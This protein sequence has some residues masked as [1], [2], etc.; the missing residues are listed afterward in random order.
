MWRQRFLF[1]MPSPIVTSSNLLELHIWMTHFTDL[2]YLLD[3]RFN[4]LHTFH[5]NILIIKCTSSTIHSGEKLPNLR[6]FSLCSVMRIHF[7]DELI[8]PL[9]H[10][11]LNLEKLDL[12][13]E[14][15]RNKGFINGIDLKENIINYMPR[16]N[17]FTFNIRLFNRLPNQINLPSN[18]DI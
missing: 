13:L 15:D 9:L 3:G 12:Q 7:Y 4:Q 8:V 6:C 16:L 18:E 17:K 5:V 1:D 10:R 14:L 11:M 2:L